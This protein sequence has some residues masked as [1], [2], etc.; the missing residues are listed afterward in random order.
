MGDLN[1]H[2]GSDRT[3]FE[4]IMGPHGF[5]RQNREGKR[6]LEMCRRHGLKVGNS[7]YK[8]RDSQKITRYSWN[9]EQGTV[10]DY[11]LVDE[12]LKP[13]L[14][15]VKVIP[16][17]SIDSD[18]RLVVAEFKELK[19]IKK[20]TTQE[21]KIRVWKLKERDVATEYKE[22]V[23]TLIPKGDIGGVEEEWSAFKKGLV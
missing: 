23:T 22:R 7:W 19:V 15:E 18:H 8:K 10:L 20:S 16:G 14:R 13:D 5:G 11:I 21:R 1:A 4:D 17:V 12:D 6:L 3:G 9:G 2:V